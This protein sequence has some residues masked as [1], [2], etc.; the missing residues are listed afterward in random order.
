MGRHRIAALLL[1]LAAPVLSGIPSASAKPAASPPDMEAQQRGQILFEQSEGAYREGRF[2]QA[3]ALLKEAYRLTPD[4]VVFY[5]LARAYEAKGDLGEAAA[6][7]D[8]YLADAKDI[9]DRAAIERKSATL[10]ALAR[11]REDL[12]RQ[13]Q[14]PPPKQV[15]PAPQATTGGPS[16]VPWIVAG[17]GGA[18]I[19]AGG[20]VGALALARNDDAE[21][22]ASQQETAELRSSAETMALASTVTMA[23]GGAVVA[24]GA[25][26][27]IVDVVGSSK[28]SDDAP[29]A[30]ALRVRVGPASASLTLQF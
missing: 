26:W 14:A 18:A 20:V 17:A 11:E 21:A 23:V 13:Q 8:R 19:I 29:P 27:G 25:I 1:A 6:A 30:T 2:E 22:A 10:K 7:F 5:N 4:P 16:P 12:K 3:I 15:E 9:P 24:A 28:R